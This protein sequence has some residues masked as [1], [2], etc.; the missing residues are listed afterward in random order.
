MPS[1]H[2]VQIQ[3]YSPS[4]KSP[5][6]VL[7]GI[8]DDEFLKL[9]ADYSEGGFKGH[10]PKLDVAIKGAITKEETERI[11]RH[12]NLPYDTKLKFLTRGGIPRF[13][14]EAKP[15]FESN[16]KKFWIFPQQS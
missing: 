4:G 15:A 12:L 1:A 6:F 10:N 13:V 3:I 5:G 11:A 14:D 2:K 7:V 16:G 9:K 8:P